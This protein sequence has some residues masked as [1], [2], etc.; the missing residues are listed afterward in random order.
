MNA[1]QVLFQRAV[2]R[3]Q[4]Q[5]TAGLSSPGSNNAKSV[6]SEVTTISG[7][8]E[9]ISNNNQS[10]NDF[11]EQSITSRNSD[12]QQQPSVEESSCSSNAGP[13]ETTLLNS[14]LVKAE[15]LKASSEQSDMWK[16]ESLPLADRQSQAEIESGA[17]H[18]I[19]ED[20]V[21]CEKC[22]QEVLVWEYSEHLDY[23][24]AVELQ[25]SFSGPSSIRLSGAVCSPPTKGKSK[26]RSPAAF[27]A[28]R[29]KKDIAGTLDSFFKR[30]P[31]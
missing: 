21:L 29:A 14:A 19:A 16:E 1:I 25:N 7:H 24:F 13:M 18:S 15:V 6:L 30:L 31:P 27:S 20:Q 17:P 12:L 10:P 22:H 5:A 8:K 3:K 28:K 4:T 23:H 26:S 9:L 11:L 2:E